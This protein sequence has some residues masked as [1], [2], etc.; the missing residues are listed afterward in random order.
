MSKPTILMT[1]ASN[2]LDGV[3]KEA[4]IIWNSVSSSDLVTAT[5]IE[6][7]GI[8]ELAEAIIDANDLF[9]FHFGGHTDQGNI[10]LEGMQHI[11][12]IRLSRILSTAENLQ[13]VFLNG[14]LS[15]GHVGIMTA[16]GVKAMIATN[17]KVND[18]EAARIA[19]FFYKLFFERG[20]TLRKAFETAEATVSG[21]NSFPIIVNPGEIDD[22]QAMP[23]SWTLFINGNHEEVS[24]W[25]LQDFL[26]RNS[27][28]KPV[29]DTELQ[30]SPKQRIRFFVQNGKLNEAL[31]ELTM[32]LP[33]EE[34]S[35]IGLQSRVSRLNRSE[36]D[37]VIDAANANAERNRLVKAILDMMSMA[38]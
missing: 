24:N 7:A 21:K 11:D 4:D 34:N 12:K 36:M 37:G 33:E 38:D 8:E 27:S 13:L 15:Y 6:N 16:K 9:M 17:V 26:P 20:F 35:I 31:E 28:K 23:S 30:S 29:G 18:G 10:V 22:K 2:D 19:A 25:T 1:F 5:K 32:L 14:C 3:K